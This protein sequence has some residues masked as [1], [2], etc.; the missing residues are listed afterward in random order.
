MAS[1]RRLHRNLRGLQIADLANH[2][3]IGILPQD[4]AQQAGEIEADLRSDLNLVDAGKLIFDRVLDRYDVARDR[5]Q[6]QKSGIEGRRLAAAGRTGDQHHAVRQ[7]E[8][9]F[10]ALSDG[11]WQTQLFIVE[12]DRSA[13]EHAQHDRLAVQRGDRRH[14]EVDLV[15]AYGQLDAAVLRQPALGDVEPR[16][17]LDAR[18][19]G[20]LQPRRRWLDLM[21]HTV[22]SVSY[23]QPIGEGFD[24]DI[25]G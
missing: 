23:P 20:G 17:D 8:R 15:T 7:C 6:P 11:G 24:M 3:D 19:D 22:V 9:P 4:R 13:V 12:L 1:Q 14:P 21:Q 25:R 2:D 10:D 16:H 18:D 5:V